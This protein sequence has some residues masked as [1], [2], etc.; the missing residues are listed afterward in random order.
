MPNKSPQP[1]GRARNSALRIHEPQQ[2]VDDPRQTTSSSSWWNRLFTWR[3]IVVAMAMSLLIEA[4]MIYRFRVRTPN[5]V[6]AISDEIPFGSFEF[7]RAA[8]DQR[9]YR[10]QFDLFVRLSDRLD[11]S[12]QRQFLRDQPR[13]QLEVE[14][15]IRRLRLADFTDL[16]LTRLK[17]RVQDRI[18]DDLGF[19]AVAEVLVSNFKIH[20]FRSLQSPTQQS[21]SRGG[22]RPSDASQPLPTE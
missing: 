10:G 8:S 22:E 6:P 15:T 17:D 12:Q 4:A 5:D 14:E 7:A 3:W 16:R 1:A 11:T 21:V 18:N 19:D 9:I 2:A 20:A 13:L